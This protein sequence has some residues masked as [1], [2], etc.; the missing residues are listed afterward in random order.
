MKDYDEFLIH[1]FENFGEENETI[2][3]QS[4]VKKWGGGADSR[5]AVLEVFFQRHELKEAVILCHISTKDTLLL[6][7]GCQKSVALYNSITF[8]ALVNGAVDRVEP[9]F[10]SAGEEALTFYWESHAKSSKLMSV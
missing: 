5:R 10:F 6:N 2:G 8:R 7:S 9:I 3:R 4:V 1:V